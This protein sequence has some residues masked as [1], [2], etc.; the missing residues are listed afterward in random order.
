MAG[1]STYLRQIALIVL[2][3]QIGSF[4]PATEARIGVVDQIFTRVGAQD[5][6]AAGA[7][8]FMVEMMEAANILHHATPR[9][10]IVLD[11][12]GRGTSTFDGL[13]I[14]RAVVEDVHERIGARTLFATHFHE[15]A[16]LADELPRVRAF[17]CAVTEDNGEIVFLRKVVPG[18]AERSYGIHVARLAGLPPRV[19][20]RAAE[21]LEQLEQDRPATVVAP[22]TNGAA[23]PR[24][25]AL[26]VFNPPPNEPDRL[27]EELPSL[28]LI[29]LT[30]IEALNKLWEAQRRAGRR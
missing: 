6:L 3:A 25:L 27:A 4:V 18:G 16:A 1:K 12:I 5:D 13:S 2:M 30:P 28:D 24:Q 7:S 29:N 11:E 17:N 19:T 15:L 8:T 26:D 21:I 14:A 20:R 23:H 9:S 22:T 10:L